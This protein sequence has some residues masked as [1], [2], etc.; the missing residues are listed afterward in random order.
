V[1]NYFPIAK[2]SKSILCQALSPHRMA[3]ACI[4]LHSEASNFASLS[5][6]EFWH[7]NVTFTRH[8][9]WSFTNEQRMMPQPPTML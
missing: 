9:F 8:G 5:W 1:G 2:T 3:Q 7:R 6:L 4:A